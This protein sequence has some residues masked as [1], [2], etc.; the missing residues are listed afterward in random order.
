MDSS[1]AIALTFVK[2]VTVTGV[3]LLVVLPFPSWPSKFHSPSPDGA[4]GQQGE[5]VASAPGHRFDIRQAGDRDRRRAVDRGSIPQLAVDVVPPR[6][7]GAVGEQARLWYP[8]LAIAF[9]FVRPVTVTGVVLS[10]VLPF[11]NWPKA[12]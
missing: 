10:A 7:D 6:P 11:P 4:V 2:S 3:V 8:P 5:A 1:P 12:L 9:T